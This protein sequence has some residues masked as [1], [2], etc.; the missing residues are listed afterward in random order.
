MKAEEA[1]AVPVADGVKGEVFCGDF[2][3]AGHW[4]LA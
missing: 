3:T 2:R 1:E 4:L